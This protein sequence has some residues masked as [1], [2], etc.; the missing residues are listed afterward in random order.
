MWQ[1]NPK[2]RAVVQLRFDLK[3]PA[4]AL[5]DTVNHGESE[6]GAPFAFGREEWLQTSLPNRFCHSRPCVFDFEDG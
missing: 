1:S 2:L 5:N 3:A 6:P 4:V